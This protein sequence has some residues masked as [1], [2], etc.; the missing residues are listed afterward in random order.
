MSKDEF[1][2]ARADRRTQRAEVQTRSRRA[3]GGWTLGLFLC[4]P[5]ALVAHAQVTATLSGTVYDTSGAVVARAKLQLKD[6]ASGIVRTT[7]SNAQGFYSLTALPPS[8][9]TVTVSAPGFS[10]FSESGVVFTQ[11]ESRTLPDLKL[12]VGSESQQV[13]VSGAADSTIPLDT[14]AMGTTLN[15]YMVSQLSIVGRNAGELIKFMPGMGQ[16]GGLGQGQSFAD[17]TV[18]TNTGPAGSYSANG[19]Q[20]NGALGYYLDGVNIEDSNDGTQ[21]TNI[22]QDMISE[23]Q[24]MTSTYGVDFPQGPTIFQASSKAGGQQYH[25]AA[26]MYARNSNLNAE[27]A[28]ERNQGVVKPYA[29]YYYPGGNFGGPVRFPGV[30]VRKKLFFWTG[31]EYMRQQPPGSL[32]EYFVPTP[33]MRAGNFSPA[34]LALLP[35]TVPGGANTVPCPAPSTTTPAQTGKNYVCNAGLVLPNGQLP[36]IDP[37]AQALLKLYPLPNIDPASHSGNNYEYISNVPQNRWEFATRIDYSIS[38][39]SKLFGTYMLQH[40]KDIHPFAVFYAPSN[41]LPYPSTIVAPT[42]SN[43]GTLNFTHVFNPSLTNEFIASYVRYSNTNNPTDP[44]AVNRQNVGFNGPALF[45]AHPAQ[46]PNI[47]DYSSGLAGFYG[48]SFGSPLAGGSFGKIMRRASIADNVTKTLGTH[49]IKAGFYWA[50]SDNEQSSGGG[51]NFSQG[52]FDFE[53]YSSTGTGNPIADFLLGRANGYSQANADTVDNAMYF[54]YDFYAQDSWKASRKLTINYGLRAT[55]LGQWFAP[56]IGVQVFDPANYNNA[57]D[58]PPNTGLEWHAKNPDVPRSGFSSSFYYD[59]RVSLAYDLFGNGRTVLRGGFAVYHFPVSDDVGGAIEGAAGTYNYSTPRGLTSYAD[60]SLFTPG[61]E[62]QNGTNV[63]ALQKG[64]SGAPHVEDWNVTVSQALP[65]RSFA[66]VSYIGSLSQDLLIDGNLANINFAPVGAY[67]KPDPVTGVVTLPN[68]PNFTTQDYLPYRNYQN[69][70]VVTQGSY[71]NYNA[72]QIAWQKQSGPITFLTNYT[73]GKALGVRDG[74]SDN[75]LGNGSLVN[76]FN[77]QA[78]YGVLA[79]DHTGIFNLAYVA[80]LPS[81]IHANHLL[82]GAV[83]GWELSGGLQLQSGA[84]IQPNAGGNLQAQFPS[85]VSN[86]LNLGTNAIQLQPILTCDPRS[87]LSSGQRFNPACFALPPAATNGQPGVN[88]QVVWPYIKGPDYFNTDLSVFKN[89]KLGGSREVQFR[90]SGF[91]F[92]NHPLPQF[93]A[94]GSGSDLRLSFIGQNN[95]PSQTNTNTTLT[96]KPTYEV[97]SRLLELALKFTF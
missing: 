95:A 32:Y 51:N 74:E 60:V 22:N 45:N 41:A 81:P 10:Q 24:V 14:G 29:F 87:H 67:F 27:D 63:F 90:L 47:N 8:T 71:A 73:F 3:A 70:T 23:V 68:Q 86:S 43:L 9:Y 50:F 21:L 37:N 30:D 13:T 77:L 15:N 56:T 89:F 84:P 49:S 12:Q 52:I 53:N 42:T 88:G 34:S 1:E 26:Y 75:G 25:G 55:H 97:G 78:N 31:Y 79:Y 6:E 5:C 16:N 62:N 19:T 33:D 40:E 28:F 65:W 38:D 93:N 92:I 94:N 96:G 57:A 61:N 66:E 39:S 69:L 17:Q 48:T 44:A 35:T 18:G 59:P 4:S 46:F 11:G 82:A 91:N 83:N 58:A 36:F 20:P 76:P 7:A 54:Q 85:T 80:Q 2:I 72:V 64:Y